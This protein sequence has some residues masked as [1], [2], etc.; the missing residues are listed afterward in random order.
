MIEKNKHY[1][2][3][4]FDKMPVKGELQ[5]LLA[6]NSYLKDKAASKAATILGQEALAKLSSSEIIEIGMQVVKLE[7]RAITLQLAGV[8]SILTNPWF[9]AGFLIASGNVCNLFVLF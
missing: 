2:K 9:A 1:S 6:E 5:I 3:I 8:A 4:T 7:A